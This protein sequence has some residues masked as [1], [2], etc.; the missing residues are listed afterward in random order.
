MPASRFVSLRMRP[1]YSLTSSGRS[2]T[3]SSSASAIASTPETG[4][5][6]SWLS[7]ASILRRESSA[8]RSRSWAS[9]SQTIWRASRRPS[10]TAL[11]T[12]TAAT[13]IQT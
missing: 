6:R 10:H 9:R 12:H 8:C 4:V 1:A 2:T 11:G 7:Q 13:A 3:P 5:R